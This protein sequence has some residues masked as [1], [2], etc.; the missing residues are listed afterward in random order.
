MGFPSEKELARIRKIMERAPASR[1]L[2]PNAPATDKIKFKICQEFVIHRRKAE[3]TQ[4]ELAA[5]LGVD[6]AIMS[7]ILHYHIDEFTIDRLIKYLYKIFPKTKFK[8][9]VA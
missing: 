6:V 5:Q 9:E 1:M 4:K 3:I 2:H 7:K 8:I